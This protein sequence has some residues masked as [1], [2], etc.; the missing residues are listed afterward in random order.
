[1]IAADDSCGVVLTVRFA[2]FQWL[3]CRVNLPAE[4]QS[5]GDLN[6]VAR[7]V[8]MAALLGPGGPAARGERAWSGEP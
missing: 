3:T 1:V 4:V 5:A 2:T 6:R 8:L 7:Y